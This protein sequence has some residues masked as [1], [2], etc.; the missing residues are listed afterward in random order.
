MLVAM[1]PSFAPATGSQVIEVTLIL[2]PPF[3]VQFVIVATP[4]GLA[5]AWVESPRNAMA[6][7]KIHSM[8]KF[9]TSSQSL[10]KGFTPPVRLT[11]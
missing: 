5:L 11:P 1:H 10:V 2:T 4:V 7:I 8:V 3:G 6:A 9:H